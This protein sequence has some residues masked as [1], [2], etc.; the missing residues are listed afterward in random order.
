MNSTSKNDLMPDGSARTDTYTI[1]VR[2]GNFPNY[3]ATQTLT[4]VAT[5]EP[6]EITSFT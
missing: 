4:L 6:C 3:G 1:V 5:L 2:P